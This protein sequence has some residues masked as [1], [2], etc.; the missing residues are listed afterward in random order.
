M[1]TKKFLLNYLKTSQAIF[2]SDEAVSHTNLSTM[3]MS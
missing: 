3:E 2:Q 1:D